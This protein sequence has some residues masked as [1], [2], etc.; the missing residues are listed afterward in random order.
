LGEPPIT[1]FGVSV[2]AYSKTMD[3]SK[4]L[5]ELGPPSVALEEGVSRFVTWQTNQA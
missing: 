4:C 3:V 1:R 2:F 5:R